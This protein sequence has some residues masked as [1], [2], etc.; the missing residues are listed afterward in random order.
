[1]AKKG[2]LALIIIAIIVLTIGGYFLFI[3]NSVNVY[4]DGENVTTSSIISPLSGV[5]TNKMNNEISEY[6]F[7]TMQSPN[8]TITSL[9]QGIHRICL[10]Y[11][12][13]NINVKIDSSLGENKIP[14]IF[15]IEGNSMYPTLTDGQEVTVEKTKNIQVNNIVVARSPEYG[16]IVKRVSQIKGDKILLTSD[17]TNVEYKVINGTTYKIEGINTWVSIDDIIGVVVKY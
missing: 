1:M 12:L 6:V 9:K 13:D 11:G 2:F 5:D 4:I 3:G 14:V 16:N 15:H 17:N 7:N 10:S 8:G